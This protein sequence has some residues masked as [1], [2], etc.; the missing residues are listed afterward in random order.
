MYY[1]VK[2]NDETL[3]EL[4]LVL[5]ALASNTPPNWQRPL[6]AYKDFDW[7]QIGATVLNQD[8]HGVTKVV[9]CGHVYTRRS[10]TNSRFGAAIWFSR[11][12]GK[13]DGDETN[14]LKLITFKD[15]SDAEPLPDYVVQ[16]LR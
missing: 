14:Y 12:N 3:K 11:A 15:S 16:R 7:S 8:Q 2:M 13:G 5:K 1:K 4:L 10:G 9:W 6:K